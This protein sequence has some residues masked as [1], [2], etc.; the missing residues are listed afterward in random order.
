VHVG[1]VLKSEDGGAS[2]HPTLDIEQDVH[3]VLAPDGRGGR[4]LVAAAAG[5]GR[6]DDGGET[7]R[8]D[9]AGLHAHYCRAVALAGDTVLVS[10]SAGHHGRRAAVY[11]RRLEGA[12]PFERC[13]EG[14]PEWFPDNVD[15]GCLAA[16]GDAA[17]IGSEDGCVFLSHDAGRSFTAAAKGLAPVRAVSLR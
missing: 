11:R 10:A 1:G 12:G 14:L 8:W 13:R 5:F 17:A 3:Q 6:S 15:T 2:W 4:V 9:N 7:W 16:R